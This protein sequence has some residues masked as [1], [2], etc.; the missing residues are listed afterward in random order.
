MRETHEDS[1]AWYMVS[2][3]SF[4]AWHTVFQ[5]ELACSV[6]MCFCDREKGVACALR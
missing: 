2:R 4:M 3:F 1:G 5:I 6:G